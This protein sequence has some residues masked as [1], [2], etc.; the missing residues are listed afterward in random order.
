MNK[1]FSPFTAFVR[2]PKLPSSQFG[3]DVCFFCVHCVSVLY[4]LKL[5]IIYTCILIYIYIYFF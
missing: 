1:L 3:T 4:N 2:F 5:K